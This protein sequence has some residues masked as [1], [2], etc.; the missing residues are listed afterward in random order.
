MPQLVAHLRTFSHICVF[1][2]VFPREAGIYGVEGDDTPTIRPEQIGRGV[3]FNTAGA[4][5]RAAFSRA[6]AAGKVKIWGGAYIDASDDNVFIPYH[7]PVRSNLTRLF[8]TPAPEV[9]QLLWEGGAA[10]ETC[11][12]PVP[13]IGEVPLIKKYG[14]EWS[15]LYLNTGYG[16]NGYDLAYFA[17]DCVVSLMNRDELTPACQ[18]ALEIVE[19]DASVDGVDGAPAESGALYA[20]MSTWIVLLAAAALYR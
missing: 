1:F 5:G 10:T 9:A 2:S 14:G 12:R 6:T 16:F 3:M 15:N 11:L 4:D 19:D 13:S 20:T 8:E 18:D 7:E 17:S